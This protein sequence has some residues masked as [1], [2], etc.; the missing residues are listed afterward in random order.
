LEGHDARGAATLI[1]QISGGER[2]A[3]PRSGIL[4]EAV[5]DLQERLKS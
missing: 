5:K 1:R 4:E 3:I 2:A